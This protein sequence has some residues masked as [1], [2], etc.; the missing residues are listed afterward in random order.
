[1][2]RDDTEIPF[3]EWK[4]KHV[5]KCR[6][7]KKCVCSQS[8]MDGD[9]HYYLQCRSC[10]FA[11]KLDNSTLKYTRMNIKPV[12]DDELHSK[13]LNHLDELWIKY[14]T[15][16]RLEWFQWYNTYLESF[17]WQV[18]RVKVL[19]RDNYLCQGCGEKA[20]QVHHKTYKHVGNEFLFELMSV[21][22]KCHERIHEKEF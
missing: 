12:Y 5:E 21:C 13:Y 18:R 9:K 22:K 14:K 4:K 6:H 19:E 16:K 15:E 8:T 20:E 10:G 17:E 2:Q 11:K 3:A 7:E 1:M